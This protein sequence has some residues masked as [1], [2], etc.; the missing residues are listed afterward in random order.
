[1]KSI[2][3]S[4]TTS[5]RTDDLNMF[6]N[7]IRKYKELSMSE[8]I[9][10]ITLAQNGDNKAKD[11]VINANLRFVVSVAKHYKGLGLDILDLINEGA[12]GLQN[13]LNKFDVNKGNKFISFAVTCIRQQ[14]MLAID[15]DSRLVR[16]PHNAYKEEVNNYGTTSMDAPLG[17]DEDGNE[18][19][20]LDTFSS[21]LIANKYDHVQSIEYKVKSLLNGL[22]A[23]EKQVI[24]L[25]FG[26]GCQQEFEDTIA[27]KLNL[28]N[29]RVRQIKHE[30]LNKM[31]QM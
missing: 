3:I 11:A 1:M 31:R 17:N 9:E 4:S 30:A 23:K 21:D 19:T 12:I 13:A 6:F 7:D 2:V 8:E 14:I 28:T 16:L 20:Y 18:K 26:L 29:E 10:L 27:K 5:L 15:N 24:V 25:T 22:T